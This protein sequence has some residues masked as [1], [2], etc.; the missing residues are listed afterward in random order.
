MIGTGPS[1]PLRVGERFR[2]EFRLKNAGTQDVWVLASLE[3]SL[4]GRPPACLLE[5]RD[6]AGRLQEIPLPGVC[7]TG[8]P[9]VEAAFKKLKAREVLDQPLQ[10]LLP[11]WRPTQP[12]TYTII[13]TYD[14]RAPSIQYAAVDPRKL[15][16]RCRE[17]LD[18]VPKAKVVSNPLKIMVVP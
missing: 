18:L 15:S 1:G 17:L 3:A 4:V 8:D 2:G 7:G 14:G 16:A 9:L 5:I 12:G 11:W 10:T 6:D 13:L